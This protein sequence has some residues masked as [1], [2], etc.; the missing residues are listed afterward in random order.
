M[1]WIVKHVPQEQ[2]DL[3]SQQLGISEFLAKLLINRGLTDH[4]QVIR[5]LNPTK[6]DLHDPNL[7]LDMDKACELLLHAREQKFPVLVY[8]DYDVDGITGT[9]VLEEFLLSNGWLAFHYIPKR[10]DEGYGVQPEVV[11]QFVQSGGRLII[12][13]DCGI[14]AVESVNL[15]NSLGCKVIITDHHEVGPVLPAAEAIINPK[16]PND[17]YPFKDLAGTG[18]AFKLV[19]ALAERLGLPLEYVFE[20]LDLVAL[21]TVA[22][23]VKLIDENRFI[24]KKGLEMMKKTKRPGLDVLLFRLGIDEPDSRDI[25][26]RV[27]PKLNAAGRLDYAEDAYRLL[28]VKDRQTAMDL[29]NL[30]FEYNTARQ[31][32]ESEI[33]SMAVEQIE[34]LELHKNSIIA[35]C[36]ENWHVGV[37][38]IV[39][40]KLCQRYGK[41][42]L[43]ISVGEDEA[44]GS[45]RS[46][47][48]INLIEILQPFSSYFKEFGGHPFAVG[49]T[50]D[51]SILDSFIESLKDYQIPI[52]ESSDTIEIDCEVDL[53]QIDQNLVEQLKILEPFGNGNPEP[54]FI[55]K[56]AVIEN[57]KTF[58]QGESNAKFFVTDGVKKFEALGFGLG[59]LFEKSHLNGSLKGDLVF[60]IKKNGEQLSLNVL[61]LVLD[62]QESGLTKQNKRPSI[63]HKWLQ[64]EE[65]LANLKGREFFA[66][67]IRT[68]NFIYKWLAENDKRKIMIVSPNNIIALQTYQSLLRYVDSTLD[69]L[70]SLNKVPSQRMGF[71][72]VVYFVEQF[73]KF[74]QM[75]DLVIVNELALF[76]TFS[77][78]QYVSK[79][80]QLVKDNPTKFAAVSVKFSEDLYDFAVDLGF[81]LTYQ[82]I[83]K[84]TFGLVEVPSLETVLDEACCFL[85]SSKS[86]LADFYKKVSHVWKASDLIVYTHNLKPQQKALVLN[87]I[88]KRKFKKLLCVTNTDGIP[89]M[90]WQDAEIAIG[91]VPLSLF[92]IM[93]SLSFDG[94]SQIV[95]LCFD[96]KDVE[97]REQELKE[98]FPTKE[99]I[100]QI[101]KMFKNEEIDENKFIET[102]VENNFLKNSAYGKVLIS[103]MKE[104]GAV[105]KDGKI[106]LSKVDLSKHSLRMAEGQL[107]T[108]Y[109]ESVT[110]WYLLQ[111][112]KGIC[113]ALMNPKVVI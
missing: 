35:V 57:P 78:N 8:G 99:Y 10:L 85:F 47:E 13:V 25:G 37:L 96:L 17:P 81:Y 65:I 43:V 45:A 49:F 1:R 73:E 76:K 50:I 52:A 46:P 5:F 97:I 24:V 7:L 69:F 16:R 15:A 88:K 105:V 66:V 59:H 75:Y 72:T 42:V 38:G 87:Q 94:S 84:P 39:A 89:A 29:V 61:D 40:T 113:K 98:L 104:L 100:G 67:D 77:K 51:L 21:G 62:L 92:E 22:D 71:S 60:T 41:P 54:V 48:N 56:N 112:A 44:R 110:K 20:Y 74:L 12:T 83:I 4:E 33:Y 34:E 30:L 95:D 108:A 11:K 102:L 19:C 3:L 86:K 111:K 93:D 106:D 55:L 14:T 101:L 18:V 6:Q 107:D 31:E 70:N 58:G 82:R 9:A 53:S 68:R 28:A 27:A 36:G 109:F 91:D 79:F 103:V 63:S 2:V 80:L 32:I 26:Y 64:L 90:L 23:M